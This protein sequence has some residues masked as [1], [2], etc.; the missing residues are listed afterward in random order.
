MS[1]REAGYVSALCV[2]ALII[3]GMPA[4]AE[5]AGDPPNPSTGPTFPNP[6]PPNP[7]PPPSPAPQTPPPFPAPQPPA[8]SPAPPP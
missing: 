4:F 2:L 5:A 1:R 6:Q 7:Q 3:F 8:P